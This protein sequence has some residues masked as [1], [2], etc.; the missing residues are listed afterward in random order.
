MHFIYGSGLCIQHDIGECLF[1]FDRI[2]AG[3]ALNSEQL[4]TIRQ[5]LCPGGILVAPVE[6]NLLKVVRTKTTSTLQTN[7]ATENDFEFDAQIVSGVIFA[8]MQEKQL[9]TT[10]P[11]IQWNIFNHYYFPETFNKATKTILLCRNAN[12]FQKPESYV[13]VAATIPKEV[14]LHILSFAN[15]RC[16]FLSITRKYVVIKMFVIKLNN[17]QNCLRV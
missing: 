17:S 7:L 14:W 5:L 9:K 12:F 8:P 10:I 15:R 1:G 13:N 4:K 11:A 6:D 16:K 2:Y 3:A